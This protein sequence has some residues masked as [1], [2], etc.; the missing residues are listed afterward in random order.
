MGFLFFVFSGKMTG[1][2][3]QFFWGIEKKW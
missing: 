2:F 3:K 1:Y